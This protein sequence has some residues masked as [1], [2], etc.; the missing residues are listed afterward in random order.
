MEWNDAGYNIYS[1][2]NGVTQERYN[3][4]PNNPHFNCKRFIQAA[5]IDDWQWVFVDLDFKSTKIYSSEDEFYEKL[6]SSQCPPTKVIYSGNGVHAYWRVSDL[7]AKSFLRLARRL[8]RLYET[9]PAVCQIKQLMRVPETLNTKDR[10]N[11]KLCELVHEDLDLVYSAEDLDKWLPPI[12]KDDEDY[13]QRH[14]DGAY[15]PEALTKKINSKLPVK[16]GQLLRESREAKE[17]WSGNTDDRSKSDYRL[18]HL[19]WGHGFTKEEAIS[20]LVNTAKA[21]SRA[22]HHRAAYAQN[23]VDKIWV[24]E[25]EGERVELAVSVKEILS[26]NDSESL[27]GTRFPCYEYFDGTQHGFRLGQVIGLVAGVGVGKTSIS[28]NLFRGF[29]ENNPNYVHMF[30]SLEQPAREIAERWQKMCGGNTRLHEKVHVLSNYNDDGSYRY[31]SLDE[32]QEYI[33]DFQK[34]TKKK[35]GCVCLDHIGVLKK[36]TINGENQGLMDIC[37]KLKA[38]AIATDT[39]FVVQS[40]S[41]REKAGIG[42][43]ELFKDAAYGTQ[44][45]ESFVDFLVVCWQPLKRCYADDGCPTV[46]A[47]KFVKIRFKNKKEDSV[48]EDQCYRLFFDTSTETFRAM[49]QDEE[50]SFDFFL[51]KATNKRKQDHRTSLV[52]YTTI[53]KGDDSSQKQEEQASVAE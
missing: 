50:T 38:F 22:P 16:F 26:Q 33:L 24:F 14:Y 19:M 35:V 40:Q 1:Y 29:V 32:I 13:C 49:T 27:K 46:T 51:K 15:N 7:D 2:P 18:G 20:V 48:A 37:R 5:D 45:F 11:Y 34:R 47:Y 12:T 28:L 39:I 36:E 30:V 4:L 10:N 53:C 44:A 41:S 3:A 21:I 6:L 17:I 9:D 25:E 8:C 42:D 52:T 31:L 23:I 43:V